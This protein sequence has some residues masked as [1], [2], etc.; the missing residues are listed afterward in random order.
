MLSRLLNGQSKSVTGA[1]ILIA[2]A[3]L[4]SRLVGLGRERIFA[5]YYGASQVMDAYYAAFKLPDLVYNLLIVGAISAGFIPAFTKLLNNVN[6]QAAWRLANNILNILGLIVLLLT[7]LGIIFMPALVPYL[8]PGFNPATQQL[9]ISFG[10][11]MFISI[12]ILSLSMIMGTILQSLRTFFIFSVAPIFYNLG[13]IFGV[14][15]LVPY[16]GVNGLA[17]GVVLGAMIHFLLQTYGACAHGYRW[18]WIFDWRDKET[19]LVAKLMIP[20]TMGLA[21]NQINVVIITVL[22]SL[23]PV[24]SVAVYNYANNL[25][26]VPTG[27]IGL[28][29]A[30]AVFPVLAAAAAKNDLAEFTTPTS[31]SVSLEISHSGTTPTSS[32]Y[33]F[34]SP[35]QQ[36]FTLRSSTTNPSINPSLMFQPQPNIQDWE[37]GK[38]NRFIIKYKIIFDYG[39]RI[40]VSL[41]LIIFLFYYWEN[42]SCKCQFDTWL[43]FI[44]ILPLVAFFLNFKI[45]DLKDFIKNW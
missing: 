37:E 31:G 34:T 14:I 19:W 4:L 26:G 32:I 11:I 30:L 10:R 17:W 28:P 29:F 8:A 41:L 20:R 12:F 18:Q 1:A 35:Q 44:I 42:H 33:N 6:K 15:V 13:I 40:V 7:I 39:G 43:S 24:G 45:S 2:S 16:L 22:A 5:H 3:T 36:T 38:T 21:I 25:Q 23:L 9:A 27:I